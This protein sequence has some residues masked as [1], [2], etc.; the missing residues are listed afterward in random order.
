MMDLEATRKSLGIIEIIRQD[1][2]KFLYVSQKTYLKR[3]IEKFDMKLEIVST[4]FSSHYKL[5]GE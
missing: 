4:P 1:D 5:S 3:I 2:L